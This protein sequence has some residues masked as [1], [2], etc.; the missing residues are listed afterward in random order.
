MRHGWRAWVV[1]ILA[2]VLALVIGS[3]F[4]MDEPVRRYIEHQVNRQLH[5]YSLHVGKLD[6]HPLALSLD[7]EN[8]SIVQNRHPDPPI[9]VIP[10]WHA[11]LQWTELMKTNIVSDHVIKHPVVNVTRSQVKSELANPTK[12][13]WQD[14]LRAI[15]P[16]RINELK[17]EDAEVTYFDH[18]KARPL[19]L[20]HLQF[21]A[22]DI[23]NRAQEQD[24]PST[25]RFDAQLFKAGRVT[26]GGRANFLT[27]PLLAL[28]GDF[29]LER[30]LIEDL[31]GLTGRY[32][33]QLRSG[34]LQ[35]E[36]QV[37]YAPW[38]K[39]ADINHFL[40]EDVKADYVYR[41]HPRDEAGREEVVATVKEM[42]RKDEVTVYVKHGKVLH[43]EF[44]FVNKSTNPE[45]RVV[46]M[47][48]NA[49]FDNISNRLKELKQCNAVAKVT[50][51]FMGTGRTVAAGTFGREDPNPA[52]DLDVRIVKMELKS[53]N[54]VLRAYA[55]I[56]VSK[57]ALSFFSQLSVKDG[58]VTGYVKP[59]FGDVEVYDPQ[60]DKDKAMTRK[61]YE[62]VVGGVVGLLKNPRTEQVAAQPDLSGP[63]TNP[64][65]DTWQIV[66]TLI[67]NA[68]FKAI[69]PRL[70]QERGRS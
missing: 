48:V 11:S 64:Q 44:G 4:L 58:Q 46:M 43:S 37:E 67:Q 20:S 39:T 69:L 68:F 13:G 10:Q 57:G 18:P 16:V 52:F 9:V 34:Q 62:A 40:L 30:V 49:E 8:V 19:K 51:L 21:E 54:D 61:W 70:E 38:K 6:L 56:D 60:Q 5:V 36:G 2:V 28:N 33:V 66:A 31:I 32:N 47:D 27:K 42:Q 7:L 25:I 29:T 45:Y 55:D 22:G 24:Y 12:S 50:G 26:F 41:K 3:V 1:G 17:V 53:L 63:V 59:M 65:A 35:A 15:F 23:S 14:A